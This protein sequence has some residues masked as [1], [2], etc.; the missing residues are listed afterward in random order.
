M[1]PTPIFASDDERSTDRF[2]RKV[3]YTDAAQA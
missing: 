1:H 3:G 2:T